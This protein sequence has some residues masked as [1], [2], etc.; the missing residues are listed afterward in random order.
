MGGDGWKNCLATTQYLLVVWWEGLSRTYVLNHA[1]LA[2]NLE[3][4]HP[5]DKVRRLCSVTFSR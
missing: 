2:G 4:G 3:Q 5:L 1:A